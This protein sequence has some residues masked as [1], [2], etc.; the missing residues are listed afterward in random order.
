MSIRNRTKQSVRRLAKG[1]G[2]IDRHSA[3][4]GVSRRRG[5]PGPAWARLAQLDG[6]SRTML[7]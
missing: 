1:T 7:R 4:S 5:N 6:G 3:T 2:V